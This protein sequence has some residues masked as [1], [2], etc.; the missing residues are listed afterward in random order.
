MDARAESIDKKTARLDAE[1]LKY[2]DQMKKMRDGPSKV[3]SII[4]CRYHTNMLYVTII[5]LLSHN[6]LHISKPPY[7]SDIAPPPLLYIEYG[8]TEGTESTETEENVSHLVQ[9]KYGNC[10]HDQTRITFMSYVT[11]FSIYMF[12]DIS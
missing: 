6:S 5:Q 10:L 9:F 3:Q 8:E 11:V 1:L 12:F 4:L 2:K 7:L